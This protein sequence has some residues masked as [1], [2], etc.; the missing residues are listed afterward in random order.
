MQLT[1]VLLEAA[2][3]GYCHQAVG[4]TDNGTYSEFSGLDYTVQ[5]KKITDGKNLL[6]EMLKIKTD[7]F[8]PPWNSYDSNTIKALEMADFKYLSADITGIIKEPSRIKY[9]PMT[10]TLLDLSDA[11][12]RAREV[13]STHPIIIAFFHPFEFV[14]ID[15]KRGIISYQN[16]V[17][18]LKKMD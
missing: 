6:E 15:N 2:L 11:V 5:L 3:H 12:K 17:E 14:E 7:T 18:L 9:L 13:S 1:A 8:I 10:T 4:K 16:F